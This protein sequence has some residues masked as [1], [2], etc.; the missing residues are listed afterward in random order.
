MLWSAAALN[1]LNGKPYTQTSHSSEIGH[2][3]D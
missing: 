2:F 3:E 1:S